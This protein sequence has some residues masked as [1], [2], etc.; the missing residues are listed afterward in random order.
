M[1]Y[2]SPT[3]PSISDT[4]EGSHAPIVLNGKHTE[5]SL[6]GKIRL[7]EDKMMRLEQN[8]ETKF[9]ILEKE[10]KHTLAPE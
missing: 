4:E 3:T 10:I 2:S 1:D 6:E 7:L 8:E 5:E 9:G